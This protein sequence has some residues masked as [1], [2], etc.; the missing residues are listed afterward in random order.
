MPDALPDEV[1]GREVV[2]ACEDFG[3]AL[4]L[5]EWCASVTFVTARTARVS[6][7]RANVTVLYGS[8]IVCADGIERVESVVV[9]KISTGAVTACNAAGLFVWD[10]HSPVSS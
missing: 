9:R 2:V 3:A 1:Q 4:R 5:A 7:K 8:E 10:A 6:A